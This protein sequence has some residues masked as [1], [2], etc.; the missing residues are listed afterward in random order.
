[1]HG[2]RNNTGGKTEALKGQ[3]GD[4]LQ[5]LD[6]I[7]VLE[8]LEHDSRPTFVID[9]DPDINAPAHFQALAP[10]FGNASLTL[11][12]IL[13]DTVCGMNGDE[14]MLADYARFRA[15]VTSR[16]EF[17]DSCDVFPLTH[18]FFGML[19]TGSTIRKRWRLIS[20]NKLLDAAA[21]AGRD[22]SGGP[23]SEIAGSNGP[24][25]P[26][27]V[28][29]KRKAPAGAAGSVPGHIGPVTQDASTTITTSQTAYKT[30]EPQESSYSSIANKSIDSMDLDAHHFACDWTVA[31]LKGTASDHVHFVRSIDWASTPLGDMRN[32]SPEFKQVANLMI[33][34]PHP[35][36]LF[37]GSDL[38]MMYNEA[39][40][41]T[42]AGRKHPSLMGTGFRGPFK[43][44]WDM[45]ADLFVEC[46]RTGNPISM[47]NQQL[48]IERHGFVEETYFT[49]S[50]T[51]LYGGGTKVLG[52]YNAPFETTL[53]CVSER[54]MHLL[55]HLGAETALARTVSEFWQRLLHGLEVNH[56]DVPIAILYSVVDL[57]DGEDS[58]IS[59]S[60]MSTKSCVLEGTLGVPQ[61]HPAAPPRLD[62]RR[63]T[64]GFV[65]AFREALRTREPFKLQTRDGT[66]PE[67]L[68]EDMQWRGFDEPC[69]EAVVFPIRPS[70]GENVMAFL[71]LGL[72]PR[73]PFDDSYRSWVTMLNHQL[74]TSLAAIIL[75]EDEIRR[76]QTAAE[77][78]A[79]EREILSEQL[80]VQTL[81]MQKMAETSSVGMYYIDASGVLIEANDRYYEMTGFPRENQ[82]SMTFLSTIHPDSVP[83]VEQIWRAYNEE[84]A[85]FSGELR[86]SKP[87]IDPSSGEELE[88]W[89]LAA[90]QPE[91]N[92]DG[93]LRSVLGSITDISRIKWAEA[94]QS[95]RLED[96]EETRR[97]TNNFL[98]LTSHEM[99]NPLSAMIHCADEIQSV[100][101]DVESTSA[102]PGNFVR[103]CMDAAATIVYCAQH[104][105]SIV[106]DIL[107]VS[108]LDS[109]LLVITP[110]TVD[111]IE[112][113]R[114]AVKMFEAE[115]QKK[116]IRCELEVDGSFDTLKVHKT[117]MDSSRVLQ[118]LINLLTNAIKFTQG[119]SERSIVVRIGVFVEPPM[120]EAF[121]FQYIEPKSL[122]TKTMDNDDFGTGEFLCLGLQVQDTGRG[123]SPDEKERL[124][125]RFS[126]ATPR[127][128]QQYGGSGLGLFISRQLTELHGGQIGVGS[129]AGVGSTFAFYVRCR[130]AA[131][132]ASAPQPQHSEIPIPDSEVARTLP[133]RTSTP[134]F[135][136]NGAPPSVMDW[137]ELHVL[138]VE[139]NLIN[140]KVLS[141]QL[142]KLG[143]HISTADHGGHALAHIEKTRYWRLAQGAL[144]LSVVLM[145]LEMPVMDGL[146]CVRH[147]RQAEQTGQIIGHVPVIAVTANAR[148]ELVE[149][150]RASGMDDV[151][152]KPF[153]I[154]ELMA[155]IEQ[156]LG[157]TGDIAAL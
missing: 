153:R 12:E 84:L 40:R 103:E 83:L 113:A 94:L 125:L 90:G 77:A 132:N 145:D 105:K 138:I 58:Q 71:L 50:F 86:L 1:M 16:S 129:Q 31:D 80:A 104:Q 133:M 53:Q 143:C 28:S 102:V 146:T 89:I 109:D 97:Q 126:Q 134:L 115:M 65:P 38:T 8:V 48:P 154:P 14:A 69:R 157:R 35:C 51:P 101:K 55:L 23:P 155:K 33:K 141:R 20:G 79:K 3:L 114:Q 95:R 17:D 72:N 47:Q 41:D 7:G 73:R 18:V 144:P 150:A 93:T 87:Y 34:N 99:R 66:L 151:M 61:S 6:S 11:H 110:T 121:D 76:G 2:G 75:F 100:L 36:A 24:A 108:K 64:Q 54:R 27:S 128:H 26:S 21:A 139:D 140:Q 88:N 37:W 39:Y 152:P 46:G 59:G 106:D 92:F 127:T 123:L 13:W 43:E 15:W 32:W 67:A 70:Q 136:S 19:W 10:S 4:G 25:S 81:R 74:A 78:A 96:A 137:K 135:S 131:T 30:P 68:I 5:D 49:W 62:L 9:L 111:P 44:A 45:L 29:K 148:S 107:T 57:D 118:V 116:S 117:C 119:K 156:V 82:D 120:P 147:I 130:R 98:D 122:L 42:V 142:K 60:S 22:L 124:F 85:P 63:S 149:T 56:Y 91:S 112:V 52:F